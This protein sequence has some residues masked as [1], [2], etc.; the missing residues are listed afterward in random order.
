MGSPVFSAKV[1]SIP[2]TVSYFGTANEPGTQ[3]LS[4]KEGGRYPS[5]T[6]KGTDVGYL[7][8]YTGVK[9]SGKVAVCVIEG[10]Y[11]NG[12]KYEV[13]FFNEA[14]V[15]PDSYNYFLENNRIEEDKRYFDSLK[16]DFLPVVTSGFFGS[17]LKNPIVWGLGAFFFLKK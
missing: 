2:K 9:V 11:Q 13:R 3:S 1:G 14:D 7:G 15:N 5:A 4:W 6:T 17:L 10:L 16:P 8:I 12:V